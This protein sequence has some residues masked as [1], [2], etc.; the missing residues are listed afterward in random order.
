MNYALKIRRL[1]EVF[2]DTQL[3]QLVAVSG[4]GD[5]TGIIDYDLYK[6]LVLHLEDIGVEVPV[7]G[8]T[9]ERQM[10]DRCKPEEWTTVECA[11]ITFYD[12]TGQI[13]K[14]NEV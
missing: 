3:A 10:V 2:S 7:V 11:Q 12:T 8:V 1:S 6:A 9:V 14:E 13:D 4:L 5:S